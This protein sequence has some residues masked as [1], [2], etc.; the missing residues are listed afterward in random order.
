MPGSIRWLKGGAEF[1]HSFFP[2]HI[3]RNKLN[4]GIIGNYLYYKK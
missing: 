2:S 4:D 1:K 3:E